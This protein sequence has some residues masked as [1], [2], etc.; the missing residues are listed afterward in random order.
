MKI[1]HILD[2]SIPL[3]SGYTFRTRAILEQQKE[4]GW[5]TFH[6]TSAKHSVAEQDIE[7]V[8]GLRFYRSQQPAGLLAKLP[9]FNQ[10]AIVKSLT[11]RLDEI[12]PEIKPDI[13]HAHSPALNGL[14]AIKAGKKYNIPVVYECRAFWEDAAVDHGTTSEGSLRYRITKALETY[15]FKQAQAVT[16]ICE[17]L[18][19]DIIKRGVA[20]NKITVI[21][22]AVNIEKFTFGQEAK[23]QLKQELGLQANTVLGFIGSFYAYEGI[24]LILDALPEILKQQPNVR[25]LLVGGGPQEQIIK[26]K[27][28]QLQLESFVI[29]TGRVPHDQVQ[30]YYNLVDIFVYPRLVMRLTELVTPLK[31]LEAMAQGR[32]V[33]ASDVDGHKELIRDQE[34]GML[35]KANDVSSLVGCV[36]N[37]LAH[38]E[39]WPA[40]RQAGRQYVEQERNWP[41]SVSNYEQVYTRLLTK[42]K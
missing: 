16:C 24:P 7:E 11:T 32:L 9:V 3:H 34:N 28:K 30:D 12:I 2:H 31:P 41:N 6:V 8:D 18:R 27:V 10:W 29:F 36:L 4:L 39:S 38:S 40:M 33:I 22:N 20:E 23:P 25:L 17:G 1:L 37:L 26:D 14:A 42:L 15:V 35:F 19:Q 13:L 5:K 21:P